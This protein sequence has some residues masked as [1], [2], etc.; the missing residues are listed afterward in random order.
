MIALR[1]G[2]SKVSVATQSSNHLKLA[3]ANHQ[4]A[5]RATVLRRLVK[6]ANTLLKRFAA[7]MAVVD[8]EAAAATATYRMTGTDRECEFTDAGSCRPAARCRLRQQ[9]AALLT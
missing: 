5:R 6:Y 3:T 9:S 4:D 8:A 2:L 1:L 7:Y